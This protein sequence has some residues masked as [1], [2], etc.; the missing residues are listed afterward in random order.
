MA[1]KTIIV[2]RTHDNK[3]PFATWL[4]SL[5]DKIVRQRIETRVDRMRQ[6][7]YGDHKRISGIIEL[8][9]DFGK[10][11]R[12]YCGEDGEVLVVLLVGG[13]KSTQERDIKKALSYWRDYNG[14]KKI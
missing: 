10:G 14:E 7:N 9:L 1:E 4:F 3:E 2:Y 5:R 11:Y 13:D 6:G 12:L 8:R